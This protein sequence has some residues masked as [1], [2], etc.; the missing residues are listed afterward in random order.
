[1]RVVLDINVLASA[2]ITKG[3]P[4]ELWLKAVRKEFDTISS[5]KIISDFLQVISRKKFQRY[6][7]ERDVVDFLEA[8]NA[9]AKLVDVKSKLRVVKQ[10]PDD[11]VILATA[12][13][14]HADYIV[15]GDKHLLALKQFKS[16]RIV[17]VDEMFKILKG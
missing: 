10:D 12:Y 14:G 4:K 16:I 9:T 8:F 13:D 1:M 17:T 5:R 3:K 11:D 2:M 7:K 6:V 15:S